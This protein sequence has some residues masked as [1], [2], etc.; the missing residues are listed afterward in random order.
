MAFTL[1]QFQ[2]TFDVGVTN[3]VPPTATASNNYQSIKVFNGSKVSNFQAVFRLV[4]TG[5]SLPANLDVYTIALSFYD[6]LVWNTVLSANCPVTFNTT[7]GAGDNRGFVDWKT[8][9][10]TI[11]TDN[12]YKSFRFIQHFMKKLG[13]ITIGNSDTDN[14]VVFTLN[15]VPGK[16]VRSQTGMFYGIVFHN[17]ASKN[18]GQTVNINPFM[19]LSF[20]E[21]PSENRLPYNT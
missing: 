15:R 14:E 10:A 3:D 9:T 2:R 6:A 19:E 1:L 4:N 5:A 18:N 12:Q 7:G 21:T 11:I 20:V 8:M 17:E 13:T 16:C